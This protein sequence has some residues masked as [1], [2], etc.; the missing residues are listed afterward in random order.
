MART[1][2]SP[3]KYLQGSG[4]LA[5]LGDHVKIYGTHALVIVSEGGKKRFGDIIAESLAAGNVEATYDYFKG[6]CSQ[7]EV[8]RLTEVF[9]AS[10]A[11]MVIGIGG[12]KIFDASKVVAAAVDVPVVI[13]PTIAATD[14]ACSALSVIYTD[15]GQFKEVQY[16]KQNPNLVLVD[17]DVIA[18]SPVRL[19]VSGMGDALA[20]YF[21]AR[22]TKQSDALT[23]AGGHVTLVGTALA[24]LCYETLIA[25]G[26]R[27]KRA[28]E[29][30][31][32]TEAVERII[33]AN[34]LISGLGFESGGLGAAHAVHNGL[35]ALEETHHCYHGEKVA[36]G[37]ICQLVLEDA[38]ELDEVIEFC[39]A[40]GLPV[41]LAELGVTD[42]SYDRV[43]E[44]A[45]LACAEG[46][47]IHAM[48]FEITP[49]KVAA[50][51][52]AADAYGCDALA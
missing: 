16:F 26:A 30:G 12:G 46:E 4:E 49:E 11:D 33:E 23:S 17:T 2:I 15:D 25:D 39:V 51:I 3:G 32:C 36:F 13:V 21:E 48:P 31:A 10:K 38:D 14:A 19:T 34:T 29:S 52:L 42:V 22:A 35:T 44:V 37:T 50:A 20:T 5:R 41:T 24:R 40:V 45:R 28:L 18:A 6:E 43:L 8:D 9:K 1:F 27:A 7:R 47:T